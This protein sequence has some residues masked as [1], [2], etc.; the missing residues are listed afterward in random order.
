MQKQKLT[1]RERYLPSR[2]KNRSVVCI[3]GFWIKGTWRSVL[4]SFIF[5]DTAKNKSW[6]LVHVLQSSSVSF[7]KL[8]S[9]I[10]NGL[11]HYKQS[12]M[13]PNVSW[14]WVHPF[15]QKKWSRCGWEVWVALSLIILV[16]HLVPWKYQRP[17][18]QT[19]MNSNSGPDTR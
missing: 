15:P 13:Y 5:T 9:F 19:N 3:L 17:S 12:T 16:G 7:R 14:F 4:L 10:K 1:T 6:K 11:F 8:G 2:K 18:Y